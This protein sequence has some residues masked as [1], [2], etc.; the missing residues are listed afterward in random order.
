MCFTALILM[1]GVCLMREETSKDVMCR[2]KESLELRERFEEGSRGYR[3]LS[4]EVAVLKEKLNH[5]LRHC[6]TCTCFKGDENG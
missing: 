6:P 3:L 5:L 4:E 2:L 1:G